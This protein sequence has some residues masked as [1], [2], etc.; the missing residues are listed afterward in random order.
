M[1]SNSSKSEQIYLLDLPTL[2]SILS[3][4][5]RSGHLWTK[6]IRIPTLKENMSIFMI[7]DSGV[8]Q[9]CQLIRRENV[10]LEGEQVYQIALSLPAVEWHWQTLSVSQ[11]PSSPPQPSSPSLSLRS[12][13]HEESLLPI[14]T[15]RAQ[16]PQL[17]RQL[18]RQYIHILSLC[19]GTRSLQ[20]IATILTL[21]PSVL[22][23]ALRELEG[24]GMIRFL[25]PLE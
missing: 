7:I 11:K 17:L 1:N 10:F 20:R 5:K 19:D 6:P 18:S 21:S 4:Q 22:L 3:R 12:S 24:R 9:L 16:D 8:L 15:T 14:R 23:V 25:S 13:S 2:F